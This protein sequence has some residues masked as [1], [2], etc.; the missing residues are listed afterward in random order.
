ML[1]LCTQAIALTSTLSYEVRG[2]IRLL[3]MVT[4]LIAL[5]I[6]VP[7]SPSLSGGYRRNP[8]FPIISIMTPA[9]P[10]KPLHDTR[11]WGFP[12]RFDANSGK[13]TFANARRA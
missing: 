8:F 7:L 11:C 6:Y 12:P 2:D 3:P 9:T 13:E 5:P 4:A 10:P 1:S